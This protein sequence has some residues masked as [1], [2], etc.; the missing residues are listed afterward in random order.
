MSGKLFYIDWKRWQAAVFNAYCTAI[1]TRD[2]HP[3]KNNPDI[4]H[5]RKVREGEKKPEGKKPRMAVDETFPQGRVGMNRARKAAREEQWAKEEARTSGRWKKVGPC[6]ITRKMKREIEKSKKTDRERVSRKV[7][8]WNGISHCKVF[9]ATA[10]K[11][12]DDRN[13]EDREDDADAWRK[14][15]GA[16]EE[17]DLGWRAV[18]SALFS[19]VSSQFVGQRQH[20]DLH[21]E[22]GGVRGNGVAGWRESGRGKE[23]RVTREVQGSTG[24]SCEALR[25]M[26]RLR[27]CC[28]REIKRKREK[29]GMEKERKRE[30]RQPRR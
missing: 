28:A 3:L 11:G 8:R 15:K 5:A 25:R 20:R 16:R 10:G 9:R 22:D 29:G 2:F 21:T 18:A 12:E 24:E 14:T 17:S 30:R 23:I 4:R 6:A 19:F 7:R 26:A 1:F 13:K 27:G